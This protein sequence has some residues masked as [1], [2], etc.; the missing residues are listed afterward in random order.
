MAPKVITPDQGLAIPAAGFP[1]PGAPGIFPDFTCCN[2][3][4]RLPGP[5]RP[6]PWTLTTT[7]EFI[8]IPV[9][10][11]SYLIPETIPAVDIHVLPYRPEGGALETRHL[12]KFKPGQLVYL[13]GPCN[14]YV[15]LAAGATVPLNLLQVDAPPGAGAAAAYLSGNWHLLPVAVPRAGVDTM[16][17]DPDVAIGAAATVIVAAADVNRKYVGVQRVDAG[18]GV[19]QRISV[20]VLAAA[21]QGFRFDNS[22]GGA[23]PLRPGAYGIYEW[24]MGNGNLHT[25]DVSVFGGVAGCTA[26]V[27]R[28][29]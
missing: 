9:S 1:I 28:G 25:K 5:A 13:P 19:D 8:C 10:T 20:G 29:S 3:P 14:Y 26:S 15:R 4:R 27:L 21:A 16:I 17:H 6:N 18:A 11:S 2:D 23:P 24:T 12:M 7:G 22:T